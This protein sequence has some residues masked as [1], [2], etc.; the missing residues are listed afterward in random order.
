MSN[1][2]GLSIDHGTSSQS[3]NTSGSQLA[4]STPS[5]DML[6]PEP[7]KTSKP[8]QKSM[9]KRRIIESNSEPYDPMDG[10]EIKRRPVPQ[11]DAVNLAVAASIPDQFT[12]NEPQSAFIEDH[13]SSSTNSTQRSTPEE[14]SIHPAQGQMSRLN[15]KNRIRKR[16]AE[17]R[18]AARATT[19]HQ[20]DQ[21]DEDD[22]D[23]QSQTHQAV[24]AHFNAARLRYINPAP[25]PVP[26]PKHI[27][28]KPSAN[29]SSSSTTRRP[30]DVILAA[31]MMTCRR[32]IPTSSITERPYIK[33]LVIWTPI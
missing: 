31:A 3:F 10:M 18:A 2:I 24:M 14:R 12:Q 15:K 19:S 22:E 17:R 16:K 1:N 8:A 32:R 11:C 33:L 6:T 7:D 4:K 30:E 29:S 25:M 9:R 27:P 13:N 26:P 28:Y 23:S 21:Y 5:I 20:Y